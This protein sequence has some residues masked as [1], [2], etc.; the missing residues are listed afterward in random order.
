VNVL[1]S[2]H[3]MFKEVHGG[4]SLHHGAKR[5]YLALCARYPGHGVPLRVIQDLVSECP[6][7]QKDRLPLTPLPHAATRETLTQHTRTIGM[8]HV[9]VTPHDEDGYVGLLLLVE[10]D[11]KFPQAY[12]VK[13]YAAPT[14]ATVL[15]RHYCTFGAYTS[16]LSDPGSAFMSDVVNDLNRWLGVKPLISLIGRHESNGTEHVNALFVGHLRR[17]VHDERLTHRW[18]S[19]TVLPLINHSLATAKN[20]ELG[21]ISPSELKFGSQALQFFQLPPPLVPGNDYGALVAHLNANLAAVRSATAAFQASLRTTRHNTTPTQNKFAPGDLILWNPREN[22]NSFRSSK[23]APKLLGPYKVLSQH[24]NDIKCV[25]PVLHTQHTLHSSRVTPFFGT[26][27]NAHKIALLDSDE[28][29]VE[30]ILQHK[31]EWNKIKDMAF[32]VRWSGYDSSHDSWEPW[33]ALRRVDKVHAYLRRHGQASKIP[34][35][36]T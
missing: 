32:L 14:V 15:F 5:T 4:R 36:L 3:D 2:L 16:V 29:V 22:V 9:T 13:D 12:P 7:C 26:A 10:L 30:D 20:D 25:H 19:D 1:P 11:T 28:Y 6:I 35:T 8:D 33:T 24:K 21:G 17:L 34:R 27:D 18:A 23:L 31:G